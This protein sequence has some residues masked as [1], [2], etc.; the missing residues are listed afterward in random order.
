MKSKVRGRGIGSLLG[1]PAGSQHWDDGEH[2]LGCR[3]CMHDP[4]S[5][6]QCKPTS[7][8]G[9]KEGW[10]ELESHDGLPA[11]G[12]EEYGMTATYPKPQDGPPVMPGAGARVMGESDSK[13]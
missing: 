5:R 7:R 2:V 13:V 8:L 9:S 6:G 3:V 11:C 12:E 10:K 4:W 1:V